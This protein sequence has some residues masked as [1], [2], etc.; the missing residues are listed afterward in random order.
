MAAPFSIYGSGVDQVAQQQNYYDSLFNQAN[1]ATRSAYDSAQA[2]AFEAML[3]Q[4]Q[5]DANAQH[6]DYVDAQSGQDTQARRDFLAQQNEL[7]RQSHLADVVANKAGNAEAAQDKI[8]NEAVNMAAWL[9]TDPAALSKYYPS[10]SPDRI[11]RLALFATA[12]KGDQAQATAEKNA[13]QVDAAKKG[14]ELADAGNFYQKII[15]EE[16]AITKNPTD[17]GLNFGL[18]TGHISR[19]VPASAVVQPS[20][21]ARAL[22]TSLASSLAPQLNDAGGKNSMIVVN[23]RGSYQPAYDYPPGTAPVGRTIVPNAPSGVAVAQAQLPDFGT[24]PAFRSEAEA[25]LGGFHSGDIVYITGVG[26]V[27]LH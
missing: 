27:R 25:R 6:Q 2:R 16:N 5:I 26:K 22:M 18:L 10:L 9:P 17:K 7:D 23:P 13:P 24:P 15:D 8:Y 1:Q 14:A 3:R 20:D 4:R 11:H 19:G 21:H 12:A